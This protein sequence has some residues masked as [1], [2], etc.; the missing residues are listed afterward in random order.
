MQDARE[1]IEDQ[2]QPFAESITAR[3]A[4][5]DAVSSIENDSLTRWQRAGMRLASK[6][7]DMALAICK[8]R[9]I[10]ARWLDR[11]RGLDL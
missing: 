10:F 4:V 11:N 7:R 5:S 9:T 6:A 2:A 1:R 8:T 3:G